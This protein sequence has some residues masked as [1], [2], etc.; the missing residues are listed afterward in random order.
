MG[1]DGNAVLVSER[2]W[3]SLRPVPLRVLAKSEE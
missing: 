2:G 1:M 3:Y